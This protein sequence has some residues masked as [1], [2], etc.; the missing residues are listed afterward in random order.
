MAARKKITEKK[1]IV[2]LVIL[3]LGLL[4]SL[5]LVRRNQDFRERAEG[6]SGGG[7]GFNLSS[8]PSPAS[9]PN[10]GDSDSQIPQSQCEYYT[11]QCRKSSSGLGGWI[12]HAVG[13]FACAMAKTYCQ[14]GK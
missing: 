13:S 3:L 12:R 4:A 2:G 7:G 11:Q 1:K 14:A 6:P 9:N 8:S 10:A 5:L